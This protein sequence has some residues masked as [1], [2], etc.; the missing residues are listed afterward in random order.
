MTE[1]ALSA[2]L[3]VLVYVSLVTIVMWLPYILAGIG[4]HGLLR[5]VG[6]PAVDYAEMDP[7]VHRCHRAH[8][9]LVENLA[10][11]AALVIVA[12]LIGAANEATAAASWAFFWAR[13]VQAGGHI[14]GIPWVRTGAFFVSWLA[15]VCIVWQI[16]T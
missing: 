1:A 9:N 7:W 8:L 16:L 13:V 6:Y 3:R 14:A 15:N 11:F 10:P 4:K 2:D 12:H 5:M